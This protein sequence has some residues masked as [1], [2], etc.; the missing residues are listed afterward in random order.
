MDA[1][2]GAILEIGGTM[3]FLLC[4]SAY[5]AVVWLILRVLDYLDDD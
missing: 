2:A 1:A 5:F 4:A 3:T